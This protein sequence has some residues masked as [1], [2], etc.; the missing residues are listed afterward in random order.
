MASGGDFFSSVSVEGFFLSRS[1]PSG[2]Y[3]NSSGCARISV[4][5]RGIE[6]G[7]S[8]CAHS[9]I[10]NVCARSSLIVGM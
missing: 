1:V 7:F 2:K 6:G 10:G 5:I 8:R 9:M 4:R 3:E